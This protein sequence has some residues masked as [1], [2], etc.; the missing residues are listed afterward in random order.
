VLDK[1]ELQDAKSFLIAKGK[2]DTTGHELSIYNHIA[3]RTL[4]EILHWEFTE[5]LCLCNENHHQYHLS[6]HR[7]DVSPAAICQSMASPQRTG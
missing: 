2:K 1:G 5:T 4:E 7:D 6:T 3:P